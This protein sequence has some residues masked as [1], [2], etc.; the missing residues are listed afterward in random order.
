M[1]V[2]NSFYCC[3]KP[4]Y[5]TLHLS[6][7]P[8]DSLRGPSF[9]GAPLSEQIEAHFTTRSNRK[10]PPVVVLLG[11]GGSGKTQLALRY[12]EQSQERKRF[13][14]IF[15]IDSSSTGSVA[16]AYEQAFHSLT[17]LQPFMTDGGEQAIGM[18][19]IVEAVKKSVTALQTPW[20]LVFDIFDQPTSFKLH[21]SFRS[22]R[23]YWSQDD[24]GAILITSRHRD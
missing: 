1:A 9:E 8:G 15:W 24:N 3:P 14:A 17:G 5:D 16:R 23:D 6:K 19:K 20:L 22:L 7:S 21:R 4:A 10:T 11:M 13:Q 12:C 2:A 18:G